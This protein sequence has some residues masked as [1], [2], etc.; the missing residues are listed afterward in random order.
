ME[1]GQRKKFKCNFIM[2]QFLYR[3][4]TNCV[5]A[6]TTSH[7]LHYKS[8][9]HKVKVLFP[10]ISID[11]F[12]YYPETAGMGRPKRLRK[13]PL[14]SEVST[15][16]LYT[17]NTEDNEHF[18][19]YARA[20]NN[21]FA[22]SSI[23]G[24]FNAE[25]QKGIYVFKLH[26]HMYHDVPNLLP[27]DGKPRYLQLY[28][29]DGQHEAENCA[30]CF[31]DLRQDVIEILMHVTQTNPY[32]RFFRSLKDISIDENTQIVINKNPRADPN[33]YNP[34][35]SD[36]VAVIWS[37][38]SST[39]LSEGP[40]IS[41]T[42]KANDSHRIMHYYGCYDLFQYPLLFPSGEPGWRQGTIAELDEDERQIFCREYFYW[43][44]LGIIKRI[45]DTVDAGESCAANVGRRVI[46]PP[47]YIGGP[48][49]LKKEYLNAMAHVQ[50]YGK[51][52]LFLIMTCNSS[53]PEIK[54]QLAPGEEAQ[55]RPDIVVRVFHANLLALK[56]LIMEKH[57]FGK[58]AAFIYVVEFQKRGLPH[59]HMLIILKPPYKLNSPSDFDKFVSAEIPHSD[60]QRLRALVLKH[61]IHDPCG[62]FNPEYQC[63]KKKIVLIDANTITQ[64][65][66]QLKQQPI[67]MVIQNIKD[68]MTDKLQLFE[69]QH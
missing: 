61:M 36:E 44:Y 23:G 1:N 35:S 42:G 60:N 49:D 12:P 19:K 11:T 47:T 55:N 48:R 24:K 64:R 51:P 32:A 54:E 43:I 2:L 33:V 9:I 30:N 46:L 41:V 25:T 69:K 34:P 21:L 22:F 3:L 53:W 62:N 28:F 58:V 15:S 27:V 26:G 6:S 20:Y 14:Q 7:Y 52:D 65:A 56:K 10:D 39:T 66:L 45:L 38:S 18:R 37:D 40:H 17:T 13:A 29:Y 67:Q 5:S 31:S 68:V 8:V 50:E 57:I 16:P 63:M 4:R 59:A